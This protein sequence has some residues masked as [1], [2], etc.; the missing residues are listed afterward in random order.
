MTGVTHG[1]RLAQG[2]DILIEYNDTSKSL[3][4]VKI[5]GEPWLQEFPCSF[6]IQFYKQSPMLIKVFTLLFFFFFG[7][8]INNHHHIGFMI[9][10][11]WRNT[12]PSIGE[13]VMSGYLQKSSF[14]V[15]FRNRFFVLTQNGHLYYYVNQQFD[16]PKG[17]VVLPNSPHAIKK[18]KNNPHS[19]L[20]PDPKKEFIYEIRCPSESS[21]CF[22]FVVVVQAIT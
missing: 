5:D 14:R 21:V 19:F 4:P 18:S 16:G 3:L 12:L 11:E 22:F 15:K 20:L 2:C 6:H 8:I 1:V 13:Y 7:T 17:E 9:Q 10:N